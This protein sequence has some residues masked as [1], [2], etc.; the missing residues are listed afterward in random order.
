MPHE[1][2][3]SLLV[4]IGEEIIV[5]RLLLPLLF[6]LMLAFGQFHEF[7]ID[8]ENLSPEFANGARLESSGGDPAAR[9]EGT[10]LDA[11]ISETTKTS[12]YLS[13]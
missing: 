11:V 10:S 6:S 5:F 12:P 9:L 1:G 4:L 7:D 8:V 3:L 2:L 13:L